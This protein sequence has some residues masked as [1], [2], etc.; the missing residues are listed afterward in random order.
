MAYHQI[1]IPRGETRTSYVSSFSFVSERLNQIEITK[2]FRLWCQERAKAWHKTV[3]P[4]LQ[5]CLKTRREEW[6]KLMRCA[7]NRPYFVIIISLPHTPSRSKA[8]FG[9][10]CSS[11]ES[12]MCRLFF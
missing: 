10:E 4:A 3:S 5:H 11:N 8:P 2:E 1:H 7:G 12:C 9:P 6:E